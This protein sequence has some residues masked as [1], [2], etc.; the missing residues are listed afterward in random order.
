MV[1]VGDDW[2]ED[3]HDVELV[4]DAGRRLVRSRLPE[5]LEGITRLHAL[6]AALNAEIDQLGEVVAQHFGRHRDA[7]RYLSQPGLGVVLGARILGEF[8]DDPHRFTDAKA[9]RNYA[10]TSPIT[11]ACG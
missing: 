7:E 2:A 4:D 8:G 1:F 6:V 11:R 9:R 10:G 3:H 5:G